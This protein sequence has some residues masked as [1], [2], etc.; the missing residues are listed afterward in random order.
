MDF[1]LSRLEFKEP[2]RARCVNCEVGLEPDV[3]ETKTTRNAH[4]LPIM[5]SIICGKC[6]ATTSFRLTE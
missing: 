5:A 6:G 4:G 2:G 3:D 1:T